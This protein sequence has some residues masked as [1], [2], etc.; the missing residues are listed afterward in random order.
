MISVRCPI[1]A[2]H[3]CSKSCSSKFQWAETWDAP[4]ITY[5]IIYINIPVSC[6]IQP[7]ERERERD[8]S[9][10][11]ESVSVSL[12]QMHKHSK[13]NSLTSSRG[14]KMLRLATGMDM[15]ASGPMID[16][17]F[18][19]YRIFWPQSFTSLQVLQWCI[20]LPTQL[21]AETRVWLQ[22]FRK[23]SELS[24]SNSWVVL[25]PFNLSISKAIF[26]TP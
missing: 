24:V 5:Y 8:R 21:T 25:Q 26:T 13:M 10:R 11:L 17:T 15:I 22:V 19:L 14:F 6:C 9:W 12:P 18:H 4:V 1:G 7:L 2:L 16:Y 23:T 3:G 20:H